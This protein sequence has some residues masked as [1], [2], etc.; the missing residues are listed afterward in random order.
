LRYG[1]GYALKSSGIQ[2]PLGTLIAN[3]IACLILGLTVGLFQ[4][5]FAGQQNLWLF[6]TV[7]LCGGMSTFSTFGL[8]NAILIR[9]GHWIYLLLNVLISVSAGVGLIWYL[10]RFHELKS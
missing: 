3:I 5:R 6:I 4:S 8:E 2:F 1:I 9:N 7:G 10:L